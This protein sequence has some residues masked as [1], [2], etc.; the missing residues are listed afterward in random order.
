MASVDALGHVHPFGIV[1]P[2]VPV[3]GVA[4][5]DSL[6]GQLE[7]PRAPRLVRDIEDNLG[8]VRRVLRVALALTVRVGHM[9]LVVGRVE[10]RSVPAIGKP[11]PDPQFRVER[12]GRRFGLIAAAAMDAAP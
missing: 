11:Y 10:A 3:V 4:R 2:V 7:L 6:R 1:A 8:D 5:V 9:A 12:A